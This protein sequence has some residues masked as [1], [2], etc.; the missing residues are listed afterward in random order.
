MKKTPRK[1]KSAAVLTVRMADEMTPKGRREVAAWLRR[2]AA[3]LVK[4]GPNYAKRYTGR[5]LYA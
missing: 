2:Q 3:M 1:E 5:Y 4:E